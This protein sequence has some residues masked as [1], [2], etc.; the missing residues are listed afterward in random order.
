MLLK[1]NDTSLFSRDHF[2]RTAANLAKSIAGAAVF[3]LPFV[4]GRMG[5]V[6]G[7]AVVAFFTVL[8]MY[9]M[10]LLLHAKYDL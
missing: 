7:A 10:S 9:T 3:A 8:S 4:F 6:G 2:H 5:M 1:T